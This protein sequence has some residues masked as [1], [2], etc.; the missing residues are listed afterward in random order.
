MEKTVHYVGKY[1]FSSNNPSEHKYEYDMFKGITYSKI[2]REGS[3]TR[4]LDKASGPNSFTSDYIRTR[5][6]RGDILVL[7]PTLFCTESEGTV[8]NFV[9]K[10]RAAKN[11][12]GGGRIVLAIDNERDLYNLKG[13]NQLSLWPPFDIK[14]VFIEGYP[15]AEKIFRPIDQAL[16]TVIEILKAD[17]KKRG[18]DG[19]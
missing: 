19:D 7:M 12:I 14:E 8:R 4:F 9:S 3:V 11:I 5:I 6:S 15:R 2:F 1:P 18:Q 16:D 13:I 17:T 10:V